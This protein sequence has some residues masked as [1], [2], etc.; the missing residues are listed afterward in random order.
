[1][2]GIPFQK[3]VKDALQERVGPSYAEIMNTLNRI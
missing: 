3:M 2:I 1:M